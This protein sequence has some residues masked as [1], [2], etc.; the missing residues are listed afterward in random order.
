MPEQL[1][2][3]EDRD[4]RLPDPPE[5]P[6]PIPEPLGEELVQRFTQV[7]LRLLTSDAEPPR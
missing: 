3:F 5:L 1:P 6:V 7:L 2:L 4:V